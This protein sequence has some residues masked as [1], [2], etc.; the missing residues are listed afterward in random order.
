MLHRDS[1]VVAKFLMNVDPDR[2]HTVSQR[3]K[4]HM[5]I[6]YHCIFQEM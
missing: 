2:L 1:L 4:N 6:L 5:N 3:L